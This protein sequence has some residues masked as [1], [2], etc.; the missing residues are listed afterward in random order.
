MW[1]SGDLLDHFL[2][3][4]SKILVLDIITKFILVKG[5]KVE[6]VGADIGKYV[7]GVLG[8][9]ESSFMI[10]EPIFLSPQL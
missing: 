8:V 3:V 2:R 6:F 9:H 4:T 1:E 10:V 5:R 7:G